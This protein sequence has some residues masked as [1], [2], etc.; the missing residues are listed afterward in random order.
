MRLRDIIDHLGM[1]G[2]QVSEHADTLERA[3]LM[4]HVKRNPFDVVAIRSKLP[5]L[6]AAERA[7]RIVEAWRDRLPP[8]F[9][10]EVER[11]SE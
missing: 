3:I 11:D 9:F 7:L 6:R 5:A 1:Q 10:A 8:D 2:R 4:Q